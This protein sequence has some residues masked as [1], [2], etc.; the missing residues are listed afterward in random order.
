MVAVA[1][2]GA[3]PAEVVPAAAPAK[4]G[5]IF[6][7]L[8]GIRA[9]A[10]VG[11]LLEH[12]MSLTLA[13]DTPL[14]NPLRAPLVIFVVLSGFLNY[15][16]WVVAHLRNAEHP[17]TRTYVFRR[18]LR[19]FPLYWA[20][21]AVYLVVRGFGEI[22]NAVDLAKIV[23]LLQT[24]D[25]RLV[26]SGVGPAW[27]LSVEFTFYLMLPLFARLVR[28]VARW[29]GARDAKGRVMGE[30]A[31]VAIF[32][33]IG[34]AVRMGFGIGERYI[35]D[36][37]SCADMLATGML[38]AIASAWVSEGNRL[39]R[40]LERWWS[41]I[42]SAPIAL[43]VVMVTFIGIPSPL[44]PLEEAPAYWSAFRIASA[45]FLGAT[46]IGIS[47]FGPERHPVRRFL[48]AKPLQALAVL[49][50]GLYLWH[51]LVID[52][53]VD[54]IGGYSATMLLPLTFCTLMFAGTL[55]VITYYGVQLPVEALRRRIRFP[56]K[57]EVVRPDQKPRPSPFSIPAGATDLLPLAGY[58]AWA[59][60]FVV[61][62]HVILAAR[63]EHAIPVMTPFHSL[64]FVVPLFFALAGF[65]AY[66]PFVTANL[67]GAEP[68]SAK[69]YIW[70]RIVRIYFFYAIVLTAYLVIVP[71]FRPDTFKG[72]VQL[73]TL[74]QVYSPKLFQKGLPAAWFE[75]A[76]FPL[77][78]LMPAFGRAARLIANRTG[79]S[80]VRQRVQ[81]ELF[82]IVAIIVVSV[83]GRTALVAAQVKGSTSWPI[84]YA[85]YVALGMLCAL[86]NVWARGGGKLPGLVE[87]WRRHPS[88]SYG[89]LVGVCVFFEWVN[90]P[91]DGPLSLNMQIFRFAAYFVLVALILVPA[92]LSGPLSWL[93][94]FM[95]SFPLVA[96][97]LA[98]YSTYL[99]HQLVLVAIAYRFGATVDVAYF[100]PIIVAG[101]ILSHIVG[102]IS[103]VL[104]EG[105]L[106][107]VKELTLRSSRPGA[108]RS[109]GATPRPR[110][111]GVPVPAA[112][113]T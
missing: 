97:G 103:F 92:T 80:S 106:E 78:V 50:F 31:V 12:T 75:A 98:S 61:V 35:T 47:L 41:W 2:S 52:E 101:V 17:D 53:L 22:H 51:V 107:Q 43:A 19:V 62:A 32:W 110:T 69:R 91:V 100:W 86:A 90:P 46:L 23:F 109:G 8:Y 84:A 111:K 77:Y 42:W 45:L 71:I 104:I 76:L 54:R 10:A 93:N 83:V 96:L 24:F 33:L 44:P 85:D 16:P 68:P 40:F 74:T 55:A 108:A 18:M 5:S 64:A 112:R 4:G 13:P 89:V 59:A 14:S 81:S 63:V 30:L 1:A 15:R 99:W 94:R 25:K 49:S 3:V 27:T 88:T 113:T 38:M 28:W 39:P 26:F 20:V 48:S 72:Y 65:V 7:G 95:A 29:L 6:P 21:L 70:K 66:R 79:V 9:L 73:Y 105:P 37:P 36:V 60:S 34:P 57:A 82:V 11:I 87:W 58:R 56:Q 102:L 67:T